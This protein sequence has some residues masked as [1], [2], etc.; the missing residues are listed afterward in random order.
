MPLF[1]AK[2]GRWQTASIPGRG[3]N[4][5]RKAIRKWVRERDSRVFVK[6]DVVKMLSVDRPCRAQNDAR[7]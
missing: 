7:P 1:H 5:A 4:D 3:I 6:L 2:I